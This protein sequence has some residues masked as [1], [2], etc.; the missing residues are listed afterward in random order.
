MY[1]S[2]EGPTVLGIPE[3]WERVLCYVFMWFSGIIF[4]LIEQRNRNVRRHAAQSTLVFASLGILG[5]IVGMLHTLFL[6]IPLL[7]TFLLAPAFG[8]V[9]WLIGVVTVILWIVLIIMAYLRP[10]F[11]LPL[12]RTYERL[13]G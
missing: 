9:G 12:G 6:H 8:I 11:V 5:W 3:K 10:D 13:L 2:Y 4:L 7:G 1:S